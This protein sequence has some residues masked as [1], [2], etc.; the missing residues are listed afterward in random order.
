MS[1]IMPKTQYADAVSKQ[2]NTLVELLQ[3]QAEVLGDKCAIADT[4]GR[5]LSYSQ[6]DHIT[7]CTA[8]ALQDRGVKP[9][10]RVAVVLPQGLEILLSFL[11]ISRFASFVPLNPDFTE[12]EFAYFLK[13]TGVTMLLTHAGLPGAAANAAKAQGIAHIQIEGWSHEG[14]CFT[15]IAEAR[16]A[17]RAIPVRSDDEAVMLAT[18]IFLHPCPLP[19]FASRRT[20][21]CRPSAYML[22]TSW[23]TE[24]GKGEMI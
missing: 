7:Q 5:S 22:Q 17:Q 16:Q 20:R 10:Q 3:C 13:A 2:P 23:N 12:H 15:N 6:L 18:S 4:S 1:G 9:A 14:L 21:H 11:A 24:R 8:E 19:K